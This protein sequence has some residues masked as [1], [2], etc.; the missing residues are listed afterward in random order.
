MD[1]SIKIS[2]FAACLLAL[3]GLDAGLEAQSS[4]VANQ[5][6]RRLKVL[7]HDETCLQTPSPPSPNFV[8]FTSTTITIP[9]SW[10]SG[11]IV[12]RFSGMSHCGG[13]NYCSVQLRVNG[14]SMSPASGFD[15]AFDAPAGAEFGTDFESNSVERTSGELGPGTYTIEVQGGVVGGGELTVCGPILTV[16]LWRVS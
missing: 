12:A 3:G 10:T 14:A 11:R 8:H 1:R 16:I 7:Y 6:A 2:S 4:F 5:G 13:G 9:T 15:Y